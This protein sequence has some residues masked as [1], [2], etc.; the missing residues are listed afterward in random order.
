MLTP[1]YHETVPWFLLGLVCFFGTLYATRPKTPAWRPSP[2][3]VH[4]ATELEFKP[5]PPSMCWAKKPRETQWSLGVQREDGCWVLI[6][7]P[8][9]P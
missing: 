2:P 3:R 8:N 7:T 1:R 9:Q 6:G 5:F 4:V